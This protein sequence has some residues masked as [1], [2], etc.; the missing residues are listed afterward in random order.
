MKDNSWMGKVKGGKRQSA[1][2]APKREPVRK[3]RG[4][5]G[6]MIREKNRRTRDEADKY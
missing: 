2:S 5:V 1:Y 6:E 4:N 3:Q